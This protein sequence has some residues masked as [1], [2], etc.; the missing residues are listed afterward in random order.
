MH[1]FYFDWDYM[2]GTEKDFKIEPNLTLKCLT[3]SEAVTPMMGSAME[4]VRLGLLQIR[5]KAPIHF[6]L[7]DLKQ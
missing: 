7:A 3:W 6:I 4:L 5:F 2:L 1:N